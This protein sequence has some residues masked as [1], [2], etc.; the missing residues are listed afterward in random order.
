MVQSPVDD[1][2]LVF[3]GT[4]GINWISEDCGGSMR[5]LNSGKKIQSFSF[6]PLQRDW[7]LATSWTSCVE[8][9]DEP[10][11][12][13][14]ELY[15]TRNLGQE[16]NYLTNYVFDYEWGSSKYAKDEGVKI[17]DERIFVT[18]D[19]TNDSNQKIANKW[20]VNINLYESDDFFKDS[21]MLVEAGNTIVKTDQFM[22]VAK[23]HEDEQR[24]NIFSSSYK[25]GFSYIRQVIMPP[26]AHL[27]NTFTVMDTSE[28][29]VFM[30]L[31][32][33]GSNT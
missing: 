14:K 24:V 6:H 7:A 30:F 25:S 15:L 13:Y 8:F 18:R 5:A 12:I 28:S 20:S 9:G 3:L 26:D 27:G 23:S 29:Q 2:V 16:W 11:K 10:C 17:P 21:R 31:Q 4:N 32:N 19:A 33:H 1:S 22:F